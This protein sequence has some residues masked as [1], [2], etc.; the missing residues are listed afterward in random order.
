MLT[1]G[2][3]L[4][5]DNVCPHTAA[6]TQALLDLFNR[7]LYDRPPYSLDLTLS[8][9]HMF[10]YLTN[11]LGSQHFSNNEELMEGVKIWLSSQTAALTQA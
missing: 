9:Y 5:L 4:L 7:E 6:C 3:K 2:V 10:T 11:W 1:Y 8:N